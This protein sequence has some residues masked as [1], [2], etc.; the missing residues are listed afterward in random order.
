MLTGHIDGGPEVDCRE[1]RA[2]NEGGR[3][4][5]E[6]LAEGEEEAGGQAHGEEL[7]GDI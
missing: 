3:E 5:E 4:N 2:R 7:Q 1:E 6:R